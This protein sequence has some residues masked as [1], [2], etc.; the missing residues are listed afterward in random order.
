MMNAYYTNVV[1]GISGG[2][3]YMIGGTLRDCH[4]TTNVGGYGGGIQVNSQG[5][6]VYNCTFSSNTAITGGGIQFPSSRNCI[7]SNCV[8]LRNTASYRGGGLFIDASSAAEIRNHTIINCSFISNNAATT[9]GGVMQ[10]GT[11]NTYRNCIFIGNNADSVDNG[12]GGYYE[13][14]GSNTTVQNC[15]FVG[16]THKNGAGSL[17]GYAAS[18]W[19]PWMSALVENCIF[20]SNSYTSTDTTTQRNNRTDATITTGEDGGGN[21][22][23]DPLFVSYAGGDYH[24]QANS[25]CVNTGT[26]AD[27]MLNAVDLDGRSRI[28]RFSGRADMGCYEYLPRGMMFGFR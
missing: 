8:F 6:Y 15:T 22:T 3:V 5:A 18:V 9:G 16:N 20:V 13:S 14:Y 25:P 27:W 23:N 12:G 4:I 1:S 7:I 28:D 24:L 11:G 19:R 10:N 26:N 17:S 2:A 21:I